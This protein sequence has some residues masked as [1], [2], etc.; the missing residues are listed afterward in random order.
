MSYLINPFGSIRAPFQFFCFNF[1]MGFSGYKVLLANNLLFFQNLKKKKKTQDCVNF[2]KLCLLV[3]CGTDRPHSLHELYFALG[4]FVSLF[5]HVEQIPHPAWTLQACFLWWNI[6]D[7]MLA[8][9]C[10]N[11]FCL[12]KPAKSLHQADV[13]AYNICS[14][15]ITMV[16]SSPKVQDFTY[17]KNLQ[18]ILVVVGGALTK[19]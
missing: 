13:W 12:I 11:S 1:C 10:S 7:F 3:F 15:I 4:F 2:C 19:A 9:T 5:S 18:R 14:I 8:W 6:L 17:C 16:A